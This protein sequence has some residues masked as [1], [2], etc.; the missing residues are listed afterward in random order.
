MSNLATLEASRGVGPLRD[1]ATLGHPSAG[2]VLA[3]AF[4][5]ELPTTF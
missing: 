4:W 2:L 1:L 5:L 3:L